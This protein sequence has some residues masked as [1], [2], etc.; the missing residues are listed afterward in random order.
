M[1]WFKFG[2]KYMRKIQ[3][4]RRI[5]RL[6]CL[7]FFI[8]FLF[9]GSAYAAE[10]GDENAIRVGIFPSPGYAEMDGNGVW[11]GYD[12]EYM[13]NIA[14][15]AGF[16]VKF[17]PVN[18]L[19]EIQDGLDNGE[20]DICGN[21]SKTPEREKKYLFSENEQGN[22]SMSVIMRKDNDSM[23]F[24][25]IETLS[26]YTIGIEEGSIPGFFQ[27]WCTVHGISPA[28]VTFPKYKDMMTALDSGQIDA[29][30]I[31]ED[32]LPG[33]RKVISF[34][35]K[36]YYYVFR[37][38]KVDLKN[39]VDAAMSQILIQDPMYLDSLKAKYGIVM[40]EN[41]SYTKAEREYVTTHPEISVAVIEKDEPYFSLDRNQK[42]QG[43]IPELYTE[44]G[45]RTGLRFTFKPFSSHLEA[46]EAVLNGKADVLAMYSDGIPYA[47]NEGFRLTSAYA[48]VE[49]VMIGRAG[50]T[51]ESLK[52]IAVQKRS[53][54]MVKKS[55]GAD[56]ENVEYVICDTASD[57]LKA[58]QNHTADALIVALPS[59]TYLINQ[60][61]SSAYSFIPLSGAG[62]DICGAVVYQNGTLANILSKG[63]NSS[64]R[65][66]NGIVANNTGSESPLRILTA[67]IPPAA[68]AAGI[69]AAIL[70]ILILIWA[71]VT[72]LRSRKAKIQAVRVRAEAEAS[73]KSAEEKNA[74]FSNISHDMRT[75]LNAIIGFTGL[76]EREKD[77]EK[78]DGYLRKI[79]DSGELL[80]S[81]I[82][83]R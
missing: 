46:S 22:T 3:S 13:E 23:E 42:P 37:R 56:F 34:T 61:N 64:S 63:I 20:I 27:E 29:V 30:A 38:D 58:V 80:N 19:S 75:P 81:L 54:D 53:I 45:K 55:I 35:R 43:V 48:T 52:K 67:K 50:E 77:S 74:F 24:G 21:L 62:V 33:Y 49:L 15:H 26:G 72:L 60:V 47:Y 8:L 69:L 16:A 14:Q 18:S 68:L 83:D 25:D 1:A 6:F 71:V 32:Y 57:C 2:R 5:S 9:G 82:D 7:L 79:K 12:A 31:G 41:D 78:K 39:K 70:I 4:G 65:L 51:T 28:I 66:F 36:S 73:E 10:G 17:I 76:A 59:A 40:M 44:I 11:T